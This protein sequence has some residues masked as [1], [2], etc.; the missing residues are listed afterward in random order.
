M[1]TAHN[2]TES[3]KVE[4]R[5]ARWGG[6]QWSP[7][8]ESGKCSPAGRLDVK[9]QLPRMFNAAPA[10]YEMRKQNEGGS[11]VV[12]AMNKEINC[13]ECTRFWPHLVI[14]ALQPSILQSDALRDAL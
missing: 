14:Y 4:R 6:L 3:G 11:W 8:E 7:L 10:K 9:K 5:C 2:E 12:R 1:S 13:T